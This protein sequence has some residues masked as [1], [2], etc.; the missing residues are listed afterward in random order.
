MFLSAVARRERRS[1]IGAKLGKTNKFNVKMS[2][3]QSLSFT[4]CGVVDTLRGQG[5]VVGSRTR[6]G[7]SDSPWSQGHAVGLR[8]RRGVNDSPWGQGYAVGSMTCHGVDGL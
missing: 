7:V 8:T 5:N 2:R 1:D 3:R 4:V 6:R